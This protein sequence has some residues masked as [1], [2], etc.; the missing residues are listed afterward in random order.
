MPDSQPRNLRVESVNLASRGQLSPGKW[1]LEPLCFLV[2]GSSW[3]AAPSP[4]GQQWFPTK[5]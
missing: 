4:L 1:G 3:A 5:E 2:C